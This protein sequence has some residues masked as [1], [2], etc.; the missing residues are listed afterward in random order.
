MA[1]VA[2]DPGHVAEHNRQRSV[3]MVPAAA[4][5]AHRVSALTFPTADVWV[6]VE[7]EAIPTGEQLPGLALRA[8]TITVESSVD[9]VVFVSGCVRPLWSGSTNGEAI[10][11]SRIMSSQ[12]D[13]V[14]WTENRCLQAVQGRSRQVGEV[15]TM[16]YM[17]TVGC[18]PETLFRLEVLVTNTDLSLAGWTGFDNPVSVSIQ[19]HG[20]GQTT[21]A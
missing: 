17:G 14:T 11:A 16:H 15:G 6:P 5:K 3:E 19:A 7:F 13:G 10:V 9:D 2:G 1:F 18:T 12:D 8:D 4:L 20:I 21:F